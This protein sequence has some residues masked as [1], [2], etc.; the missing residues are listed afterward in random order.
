MPERLMKLDEVAKYFSMNS[1]TLRRLWKRGEFPEPIR[2][3][4]CLRWRE[5][6]LIDFVNRKHQRSQY[7]AAIH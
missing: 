6:A 1:R 2:L 3:G 5:Q 7:E 4:K